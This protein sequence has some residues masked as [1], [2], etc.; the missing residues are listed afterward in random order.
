L[1]GTTR[2]GFE[3]GS[4][5]MNGIGLNQEEEE[6]QWIKVANIMLIILQMVL[7]MATISPKPKRSHSMFHSILLGNTLAALGLCCPSLKRVMGRFPSPH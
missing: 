4:L 2:S 6:S 3:F 7:L 5:Q 1:E